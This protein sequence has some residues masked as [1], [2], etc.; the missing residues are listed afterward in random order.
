MKPVASATF[1]AASVS[2]AAAPSP[3]APTQTYTC[4]FCNGKQ[5]SQ[6]NLFQHLSQHVNFGGVTPSKSDLTNGY[7]SFKVPSPINP[8]QMRLK[9]MCMSCGKMFGKEQPVKIHLNVHYG[10]NIYNCRFCEKVFAN[11]SAFEVSVNH[12][13]FLWKRKCVVSS[14]ISI[15]SHT[16]LKTI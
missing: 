7:M 8:G 6:D 9:Y 4:S 16:N 5:S 13:L 1:E 15:P 12:V 2:A 10:D 14:K 11:Y 3:P